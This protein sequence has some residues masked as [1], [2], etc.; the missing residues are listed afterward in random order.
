MPR[1]TGEYSVLWHEGRHALQAKKYTRLVMG[2][3]YLFPL[4]LIPIFGLLS[5]LSLW[6]LIP[7]ALCFLP[8]PAYWRMKM[9]V[10]GYSI[11]MRCD[12]Y[13]GKALTDDRLEVYSKYFTGW[14]YYKMWPFKKDIIRRL[15]L[16]RNRIVSNQFDKYEEELYTW[17]VENSLTK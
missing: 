9:E 2:F 13:E 16:Q 17:M 5:I 4:S 10:E 12:Y 8:W 11:S 7:T 14:D 15:V 1:F 6:F 3:L